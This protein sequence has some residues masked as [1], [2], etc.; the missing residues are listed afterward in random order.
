MTTEIRQRN[1]VE[2]LDGRMVNAGRLRGMLM[3]CVN[4]CC[5]GHTHRGYAPVPGD[6]YHAEWEGRKLRN[7]IHLNQSGCLGPCVLANVATL[8]LDG[9][10]YWFHS[11]NDDA[12]IRAIY[13]YIELLLDDADA[14]LPAILAPHLF[15]GFAWDGGQGVAAP[16]KP[17]TITLGAGILVLSQADTD[18]LTLTQAR[19]LLPGDFA[20]VQSAQVGRLA[21]DEAV[22]ALL[23]QLLPHAQI[24]VAR[25]HSTRS[26]DHGLAR[27]ERWAAET[28]GFLLCLPAVEAFDPALMALSNVGIPLAQAISVYFQ[29]GGAQNIANGLLCLSDHLLVSGWGFEPPEEL[30]LHGVYETSEW[31]A[32]TGQLSPVRCPLTSAPTVGIL[33]YRAHLLSG[34]TEFV[35]AIGTELQRR[36]FAV[37]AV[38][39]QSLKESDAT[40]VPL[41]LKLLEDAGPIHLIVNTLSFALG[42]GGQ[43]FA[44]VD[45]P[46]IQ[47]ITSSSDHAAWQ[48]N[49]RG[50]APLDTAMNVAIPEFDG[51][52]ISIPITFKETLPDGG[53]RYAPAAERIA[54]LGGMVE[55][56]VAL[57]RKPN[58]A[59]RIAFVFTNSAAK[60]ARV[61]N[62][63]GLDAPASL[64]NLLQRMQAAGYAFAGFP[65]DSDTLLHNLI[66]RCSYD[67]TWLTDAQ[68]ARAHKLPVTQYQ[69]WF[70]RA[71]VTN[72]HAMV[73][74]WGEPP[75]K[76]YTHEGNFALAGLE[77]GN[78]FVALQ[79]PRGYDMNPDEVYH[80]PDL[81]P[82]HNYY[83]LYRWLRDEWRADAIIHMGKHGTLEW[84]PGKSVGLSNECFPDLFLDD[85]PLI[86]PFII[87]DPGEGSQAKR[88]THAT[89]IDHMT[90]PMTS[91]GAY[92]ALV[93]LAQLVDEYYTAEQLDPAKLPL[94]QRQIWEVI[95]RHRLDDDLRYLLSADHGDHSHDWDGAFLEDGTPT[96]F[97]E[98]QGAQV[99]HLLED[100][101]GY[102]CELTGAQIRDGL[103]ILGYVPEN[104]QLVELLYH[105][106]KLPNLQAPSLPATVSHLWGEDWAALQE[107]PGTRRTDW[108]ARHADFKTNADLLS[109]IE[110]RCKAL[111]T[112]LAATN[113]NA[114]A[115][116]QVVANLVLGPPSLF[117]QASLSQPPISTGGRSPEDEARANLATTLRYA[118]TFLVPK[119]GEGAQAEIDNLLHALNGGYIPPGPS[120]A[121]T[122]GMAHVLPTGRNFYSVDPRA[123]PTVASWQV[124]QGL[125]NDLLKRYGREEG[126]YPESVGIS[127]WGTSAMRT[128]GDD[129]AQVLALLG[130][131][132]VWQPENRRVTGIELIPLAEL[133]RPRIDVVCRIS[134]FFR[135]AFPHLITLIDSAVQAVMD[136]DEPME[137]NFPRKHALINET[138]LRLAGHHSDTNAHLPSGRSCGQAEQATFPARSLVLDEQMIKAR[139]RYRIFGCKPGSY[140]AGILPLIDAK[141]WQS[142]AD[143]AR[144]YLTWGGYAY[145]QSEQGIPAQDE[146]ATALKTVQVATKNQDNREHDIFDSDDYLQYHGGMIATVRALTGKNPRRYFGDSSDPG[147]VQT[148]DLREEARRVF[149]SRVVN[150]KWL[151][152]M[153]RHGYK[154]ALEVAAT[155]DYLFGYDATA[156]ILDDWM[157]AKVAEEFLRNEEMQQFFAESNPWAWQAIAER[158]LEAV[159]R[160]LWQDP[161]PLDMELLQAA[162][163]IGLADLQRRQ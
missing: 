99:A 49:G 111:L 142:D 44:K 50:L 68:L 148:R 76:A 152:S 33:F 51:R 45:A 149:R 20:S 96:A 41:A 79:P 122:R 4:G 160:G 101:E 53:A 109:A 59:K 93:E 91:A 82:P 27:L 92:G 46:I 110:Q 126:G 118:C 32:A 140:G 37:R 58:A 85:L 129:I 114:D 13:D 57:R 108:T 161:D 64:L 39:T 10:P 158:L 146:F 5:C 87:N 113:W 100:I 17:T 97:A 2:R 135:D 52:I 66:D 123:L 80:R 34:N 55:R 106:L 137:Q 115:V 155:V 153:R 124:G 104:E 136:A 134:G 48:R 95:Q 42:D 156:D 125:A 84:L 38:Y 8:L 73:R 23:D 130:V 163:E 117:Q 159:E 21:D 29:C 54:R 28:N 145:S 107:A 112:Q 43:A 132:P 119:L 31:R 24:V 90:P 30:P 60:A 9:R 71:P 81:P 3:V 88:R 11:I 105:L 128:A 94:L 139:A 89:I 120:G 75:G 69:Q 47:A 15:N 86:Y 131:R 7:K 40:G 18:L 133:G 12:I 62:A 22:D 154:G 143:F 70:D 151:A 121:P 61:G 147:R 35:D 72:Q 103:H 138:A 141:N 77:F 19:A 162:Q 74:Q 78:A 144:A 102:L 116:G 6:L 36:G 14:Q 25:L 65:A 157:Y 127:I 98:L 56:M 150:P 26:F 1:M 83:A 16:A 63:V 67:T